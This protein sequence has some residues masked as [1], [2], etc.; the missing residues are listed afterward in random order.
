MQ[1]AEMQM[2]VYNSLTTFVTIQPP[3][4]K[5]MD[6]EQK[7]QTFTRAGVIELLHQKSICGC[8]NVNG[9]SEAL[10][11]IS[12]RMIRMYA[13]KGELKSMPNCGAY[14]LFKVEDVADWLLMHPRYIVKKNIDN[15][16]LTVERV[17][18][19]SAFIRNYTSKQWRGLLKYMEVDDIVMEVLQMVCRKNHSNVTDG[20]LVFRALATLYRKLTRRP[21]LVSI[22]PQKMEKMFSGDTDTT[23]EE[24]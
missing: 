19:L 7:S 22:E 21:S 23:Y 12:P 13:K 20:T 11:T 3:T 15:S 24:L 9:L 10:G 5:K 14:Y 16:D 18:Q 17:E 4:Q 2:L 8:I 6:Q 1:F